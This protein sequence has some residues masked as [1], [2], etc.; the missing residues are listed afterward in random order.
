MSDFI[1][2]GE[3]LGQ[4]V[5]VGGFLVRSAFSFLF[6]TRVAIGVSYDRGS[7]LDWGSQP[8]GTGWPCGRV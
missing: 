6:G 4:G 3:V 2:A 7:E 5:Q 1:E 8:P